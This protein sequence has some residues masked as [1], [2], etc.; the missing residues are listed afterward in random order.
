MSKNE[1]DAMM[2]RSTFN[3]DMLFK[4]KPIFSKEAVLPTK[5]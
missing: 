5:A 4:K 1:A 3:E 2:S